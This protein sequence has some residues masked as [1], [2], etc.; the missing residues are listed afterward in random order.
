[1]NDACLPTGRNS[2]KCYCL[3][4]L[5][6]N[7]NKTSGLGLGVLFLGGVSNVRLIVGARLQPRANTTLHLIHR[8]IF[9]PNTLKNRPNIGQNYFPV[10]LEHK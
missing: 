8:P 7:K 4:F 2:L 9:V 3:L 1:M 6:S 10:E 5:Y